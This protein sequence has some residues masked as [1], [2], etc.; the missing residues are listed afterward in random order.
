MTRDWIISNLFF[1]LYVSENKFSSPFNKKNR[2]AFASSRH[3]LRDLTKLELIGAVAGM[4]NIYF[5]R[6]SRFGFAVRI[7][8]PHNEK[9]P[10][11][12]LFAFWEFSP[13]YIDIS[14]PSSPFGKGRGYEFAVV[15]APAASRTAK[16]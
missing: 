12:M 11:W 4:K 10:F 8:N 1:C 7:L 16:S 13:N 15:T 2:L 9:H 14:S 3:S 5:Q 6:Y